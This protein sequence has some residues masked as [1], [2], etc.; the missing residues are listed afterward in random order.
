VCLGTF[1]LLAALMML[2]SVLD[3]LI[4]EL[5]GDLVLFPPYMNDT[6]PFELLQQS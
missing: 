4:G 2:K 3:A 1:W 5:V 6:I